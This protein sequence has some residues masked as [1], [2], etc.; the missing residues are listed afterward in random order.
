VDAR[1]LEKVGDRS[2]AHTR[3]ALVALIEI[4]GE[5]RGRHGDSN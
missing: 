3:A 1:L 4:D 5:R 2:V